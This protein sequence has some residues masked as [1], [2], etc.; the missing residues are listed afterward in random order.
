MS[1]GCLICAGEYRSSRLPGL[2]ECADCG[3][4]T[5]DVKI[6]AGD[7]RKLYSR[8]YFSG[9]EYKDYLAER[10]LHEKHFRRRLRLLRQF[11]D[12]PEKKFLFEVG[13]AYGFFLALAREHF[14]RTGGIDI[15]ADAAGYAAQTLGLP[16]T[17]GDFLDYELPEAPDVV[18]LWDTIE[19]LEKPDLYLEKLSSRMRPGGLVAI[20][21]GDIGSVIARLRGARWRQ[22]HPPT[23]L[24]YFSKVTLNR[25][26]TRCGFEVCHAAY[27]GTYRSLDTTAYIIFSIKRRRPEIYQLLKKTGLLG[28]SFYL[29]LYDIMLVMARKR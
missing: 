7:L 27:E 17:V 19:H 8:Q 13:C 2:L 29:N 9:G 20:T 3:F 16:A 14:R 11:V 15:S 5:A 1:G 4:I 26:L 21:T 6:S 10:R 18:C 25:L 22:I 12:Q 24:H 23:H 28:I